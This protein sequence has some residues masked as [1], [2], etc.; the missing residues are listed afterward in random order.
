MLIWHITQNSILDMSQVC[1][2]CLS[3][4]DWAIIGLLVPIQYLQERRIKRYIRIWWKLMLL[5]EL[6]ILPLS[7]IFSIGHPALE[8]TSLEEVLLLAVQLA[9]VL[10]SC[11]T[12]ESSLQTD[13]W[14]I[15]SNSILTVYTG[16][17]KM[18]EEEVYRSLASR[19]DESGIHAIEVVNTTVDINEEAVMLIQC[20]IQVRKGRNGTEVSETRRTYREFASLYA[21]YQP[22]MQK[23]SVPALPAPLSSPSIASTSELEIRRRQF[24]RLLRY[25]VRYTPS[26]ETL[27][28]FLLPS[29]H[30]A[31]A[32][33]SA[34]FV[35]IE[36]TTLQGGTHREMRAISDSAAGLRAGSLR[37]SIVATSDSAGR[38][39]FT[40][41]D[42]ETVFTATGMR[43]TAER[44]YTEFKSLL[45]DLKKRH[46]I[47]SALPKGGLGV[48][49]TDQRVV[50]VR[51][52]ALEALLQELV[53]RPEVLSEPALLSFLCLSDIL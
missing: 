19:E 5:A 33:P 30:Y 51:K 1:I 17:R 42:I 8:D 4:L 24:E 53:S 26:D 47:K 49:S 48:S 40:L 10:V 21:S 41:Y 20:R 36:S 37:V 15:H 18:S 11:C 14:S 25:M 43:T 45:K 22:G 50:G 13:E 27:N 44:R 28:R 3:C 34:S 7:L 23:R 29:I 31:T 2:N 46:V 6:F 38:D 39:K 32:G 9:L 52:I 16:S 12:S 35:S